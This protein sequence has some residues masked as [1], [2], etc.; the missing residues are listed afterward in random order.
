MRHGKQIPGGLQTT[1]CN[2]DDLKDIADSRWTTFCLKMYAISLH[3]QYFCNTPNTF[4]T[5]FSVSIHVS[6]VQSECY[7]LLHCW[8]QVPGYKS[9]RE[10]AWAHP[11]WTIAGKWRSNVNWALVQNF[12]VT[13][14]S[15]VSNRICMWLIGSLCSRADTL[16]AFGGTPPSLNIRS[17][18][19]WVIPKSTSVGPRDL[20]LPFQKLRI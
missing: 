2:A 3:R 17:E 14:S 6:S 16:A 12:T 9:S 7:P 19:I 8:I 11:N 20:L 10:V 5:P 15:W 1:Y 4:L 13:W 18:L